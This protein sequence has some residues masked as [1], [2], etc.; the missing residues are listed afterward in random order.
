VKTNQ[1]S[2][3][4]PHKPLSSNARKWSISSRRIAMFEIVKKDC[5]NLAVT[6]LTSL[7]VFGLT[8][9]TISL[10]YLRH[11]FN[12]PLDPFIFFQFLYEIVGVLLLTVLTALSKHNI[13]HA[14]NEG[15]IQGIIWSAIAVST[16]VVVRHLDH[17]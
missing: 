8:L 2:D 12:S 9:C 4:T 5:W 11:K 15:L 13:Q 6:Y 16:M 14:R 7:S 3:L 1:D 17:L 10:V